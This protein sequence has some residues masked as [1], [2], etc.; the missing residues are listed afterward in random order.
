MIPS[1]PWVPVAQVLKSIA[2]LLVDSLVDAERL[3]VVV[4]AKVNEAGVDTVVV[5]DIHRVPAG[6]LADGG[7][8]FGRP[9]G[10]R[11]C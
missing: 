11:C 5:E 4:A 10:C 8:C 2:E 9:G 6:G 7:E 3:V 1:V